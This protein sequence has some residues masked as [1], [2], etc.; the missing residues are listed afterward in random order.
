MKTTQYNTINPKPSNPSFHLI[1]HVLFHLIFH[2]SSFHVLFHY[3][4]MFGLHTD[5]KGLS[6]PIL[7]STAFKSLKLLSPY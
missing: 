4:F 5:S 7:A 1:V 2:Y 3:P 6:L